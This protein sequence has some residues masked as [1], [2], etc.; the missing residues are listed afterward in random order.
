M[1]RCKTR[2]QITK[3][4]RNLR[5]FHYYFKD[6]LRFHDKTLAFQLVFIFEQVHQYQNFQH[7]KHII[8]Q[9]HANWAQTNLRNLL[10]H[11]ALEIFQASLR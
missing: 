4:R 5:I 1:L 2:I 9:A 8:H 3:T 11:S 7:D 10:P 6:L